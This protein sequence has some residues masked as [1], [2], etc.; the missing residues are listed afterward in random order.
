MSG[1]SI[2]P[3]LMTFSS[4]SRTVR[5]S[6]SV[7]SELSV[8]FSS[9]FVDLGFEEG[10]GLHVLVDVGLA[11]TLRQDLDAAVRKLAHAHDHR[12]GAGLVDAVRIR[13]LVA[14][15]LFG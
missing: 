8:A 4:C 2:L 5:M 1:E 15:Y 7:S 14:R 11:K 12:D 13:M 10:V 3:R 9:I 6:A